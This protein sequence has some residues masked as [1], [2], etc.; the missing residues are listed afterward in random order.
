MSKNINSSLVR[1]QPKKT[2][3]Y[4]T[5]ILLM[6]RKELNQI[7]KQ[8]K[9]VILVVTV[10]KD[11]CVGVYSKKEEISL[12]QLDLAIYI[13]SNQS[14]YEFSGIWYVHIYLFVSYSFILQF[15]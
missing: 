1:V 12:C 13:D 3:P 6:G 2:H 9:N 11:T 7:N 14:I 10:C 15:M 8:N 5:E 4:I